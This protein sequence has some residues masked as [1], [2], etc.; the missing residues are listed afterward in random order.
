MVVIIAVVNTRMSSASATTT[1]GFDCA[2][3]TALFN[4]AL[5]TGVYIKGVKT[6]FVSSTTS[7]A[8]TNDN[9]RNVIAA[10]TKIYRTIEKSESSY[11]PFYGRDV[12]N[13]PKSCG[14]YNTIAK[15][16]DTYYFTLK[17][18]D[19]SD[20][21]VYFS[22][23][24]YF[25][26]IED[27]KNHVIYTGLGNYRGSYVQDYY[28]RFLKGG[29][30]TAPSEIIGE[31]VY[32]ANP[33]FKYYLN[34]FSKYLLLNSQTVKKTD[35]LNMIVAA[36]NQ[37]LTK[38]TDGTYDKSLN[39]FPGEKL[40]VNDLPGIVMKARSNTFADSN[41]GVLCSGS[42]LNTNAQKILNAITDK[43]YF[44]AYLKGVIQAIQGYTSGTTANSDWDPN[45]LIINDAYD[46]D[47]MLLSDTYLL[48][49]SADNVYNLMEQ[50]GHFDPLS[51]TY[52]LNSTGNSV[53]KQMS[54]DVKKCAVDYLEKMCVLA[55]VPT[56]Y[57]GEVN[58]DRWGFF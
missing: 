41:D 14:C 39:P 48:S 32:L 19:S 29:S 16:F 3:E 4:T 6:A 52:T 18:Y 21:K 43:K 34:Y 47:V 40:R 10:F 17:N 1:E 24:R 44:V 33:K 54:V 15:N 27:S 38:Y 45:G 51:N 53:I 22:A 5:D 35:I 23:L 58:Y 13:L 37:L 30:Y 11:N 20:Q 25:F 2:S 49:N 12:V 31:T 56:Q 42:K 8:Y 46:P 50:F 9:I 57:G 55:F 28:D 36:A 7:I 26:D